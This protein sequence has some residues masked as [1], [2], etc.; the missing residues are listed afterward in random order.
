MSLNTIVFFSAISIILSQL[1]SANRTSCFISKFFKID[2]F[3]TPR[4]TISFF[5]YLNAIPSEKIVF[6]VG[7]VL[8]SV[9]PKRDKIFSTLVF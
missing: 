6:F 3:T 1:K 2:F 8:I 7:C 5:A 9:I 4:L